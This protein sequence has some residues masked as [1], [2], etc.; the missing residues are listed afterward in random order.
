MS[1]RPAEFDAW[2]EKLAIPFGPYRAVMR[3]HVDGD[4]FDVL[5]DAG[6]NTYAYVT[7]RLMAADGEGNL[8][9]VDAPEINRRETAAA[10]RAARE[11]VRGLLGEGDPCLIF[12]APDPDSFGRYLAAVM[13]SSGYDLGTLMVNAGHARM[14][15]YRVAPAEGWL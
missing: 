12:T 3:H 6:F 11:W 2:P 4:T 13:L 15:E 8:N 7:V 10:G 14:R 1:R 9:G 5:A